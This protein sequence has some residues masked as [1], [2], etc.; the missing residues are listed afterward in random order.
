MRDGMVGGV[1]AD[2]R[3]DGISREL[4]LFFSFL[5]LFL[6]LFFGWNLPGTVVSF[7]DGLSREILFQL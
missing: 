2:R 3:D 4:G 5:F 1:I 7:V 6:F